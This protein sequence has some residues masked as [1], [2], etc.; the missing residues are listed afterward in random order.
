MRTL[1]RFLDSTARIVWDAGFQTYLLFARIESSE[2]GI[3]FI[4]GIILMQ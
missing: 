3:F 2:V 1:V 4:V